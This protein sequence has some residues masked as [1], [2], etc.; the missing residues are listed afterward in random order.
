MPRISSPKIEYR[1]S[2]RVWVV[3][4]NGKKIDQCA[5]REG[6]EAFVKG[7]NELRGTCVSHRKHFTFMGAAW[8]V[9]ESGFRF[10]MECAEN[11]EPIEVYLTDAREIKR[12]P[13]GTKPLI[14]RNVRNENGSR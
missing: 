9:S 11:D 7:W 3:T 10:L 6:C 12:A 5:V 14:G 2:T 4:L 1:P 8:S 13:A